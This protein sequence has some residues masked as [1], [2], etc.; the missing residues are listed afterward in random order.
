MGDVELFLE[1]LGV[2]GLVGRKLF[3]DLVLLLHALLIVGNSLLIN[4]LIEYEDI[5]L[6]KFEV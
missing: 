6:V 3:E 4:K 1:L 2:E 5:Y